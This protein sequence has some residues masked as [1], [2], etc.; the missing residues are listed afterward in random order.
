MSF[1]VPARPA[2]WFVAVSCIGAASIPTSEA[3]TFFAGF[4]IGE[5]VQEVVAGRSRSE[6]AHCA[7]P[8]CASDVS[9]SAR[10]AARI[11]ALS[12][13]QLATTRARSRKDASGICARICAQGGEADGVGLCGS[14]GCGFSVEGSNPFARSNFSTKDL[15]FRRV[16]LSTSSLNKFIRVTPVSHCSLASQIS[17]SASSS[18]SAPARFFL[19]S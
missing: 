16:K 18:T 1:Y 13:G 15:R 4:T 2:E 17:R 12:S 6:G 14:G 7:P 3:G 8:F 11:G 9:T 19:G 10:T 5:P